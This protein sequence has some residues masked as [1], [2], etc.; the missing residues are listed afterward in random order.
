M[1]AVLIIPTAIIAPLALFSAFRMVTGDP[2]SAVS[3]GLLMLLT[4]GALLHARPG[5]V[6]GRI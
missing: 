5:R 1:R 4:L 2:S 6:L 3:L